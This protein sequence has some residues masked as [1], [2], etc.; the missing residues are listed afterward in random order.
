MRNLLKFVQIETWPFFYFF[1]DGG[2]LPCLGFSDV[3][4]FNRR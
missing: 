4:N 2:R 1:R 3:R